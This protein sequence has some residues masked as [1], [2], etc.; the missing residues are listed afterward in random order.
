M[1]GMSHDHATLRFR[2]ACRDCRRRR[3]AQAAAQAHLEH[4]RQLVYEERIEAANLARLVVPQKRHGGD[5]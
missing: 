3:E 4:A 5:T 2:E 1:R